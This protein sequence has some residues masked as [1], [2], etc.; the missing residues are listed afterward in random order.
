MKMKLNSNIR[1]VWRWWSKALGEKASQC[2]KESD[3][4]AV[5]RTFI[6]A[7]YLITNGFIV[8]NAVRH[9]ND[10]EIKVEVL[11]Y[12]NPNYSEELHTEGWNTVGMGGNARI[13][14]VHHSG[15]VKANRAGEFE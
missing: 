13:T 4:V 5:I 15:T 3:K 8:A 11:I 12:E 7:T 14:G 1:M 6:F 10:K 9:W 2:D